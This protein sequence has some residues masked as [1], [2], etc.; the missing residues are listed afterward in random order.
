VAKLT[1]EQER[2]HAEA[3]RLINLSR[4]L[5]EDEREFVLNHW[6]ESSTTSSASDRAHFTP[7]GL[8]RDMSL[9]VGGDR[10]ID[11][12]A[13]IGRLAFHNRDLWGRWPHPGPEMTC[14]ERNP[15]YVRVGRRV[16][17]EARWICA[18]VMDLPKMRDDLGM[19]DVCISNP[20]FGAIPR[21]GNAPGGY[22]GRRFEYHVIAL[23][24]MVARRGVFIIPQTAAP[25]HYSGKPCF[26]RDRGDDEY[27]KF[28]DVTGIELE[29]TLGIDTSYYDADW[30][31]VSPRVEIVLVDFTT[32]Q[33]RPRAAATTGVADGAGAGQLQ[34][35]LT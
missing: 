1:R 3:C 15:D 4:D 2:L 8:A 33:D 18:D 16:M 19:H 26:E 21:T 10:I 11:L 25:F 30:R 12:C 32:R 20:P 6:L 17:P 34:L 22:V 5:T 28:I 13:G 27:R 14:I 9:E 35:V 23:A 31:G 7:A 29:P 24:A